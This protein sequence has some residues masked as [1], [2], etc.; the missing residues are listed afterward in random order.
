MTI[1]FPGDALTTQATEAAQLAGPNPVYIYNI[2]SQ[3]DK[4]VNLT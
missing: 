4:Q 1:S 3:P 2:A